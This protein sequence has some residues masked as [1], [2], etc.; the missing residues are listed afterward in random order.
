MI[1]A[2]MPFRRSWRL[3]LL[4]TARIA[5]SIL[6]PG[7]VTLTGAA[8]ME[9]SSRTTMIV[10]ARRVAE[11]AS[12][13]PISMVRL[14]ED[15]LHRRGAHRLEDI[16]RLAP[17]FTMPTVG[18]FGAQQPTIRGVY[19]NIG[20][21]TVGIYLDDVP[22]QI[23]SLEVAGNPDLRAFDLDRVEV[24]RGPQGTLFGANSMGGTIRML[25]RQP[26][27]EGI[28]GHV[29]GELATTRRGGLTR[30]LAAALGGGLVPERLGV[31]ASAYVRHDAG[32]VDRIDWGS[33]AHM[34][35]NIDAVSALGLRLAA[36]AMLGERLEVTPAISYQ[37]SERADLPFYE[38]QR[39][40]FR[41]S[42]S[43]RQPGR[44]RFLLPSLTARLDL[45]GA[46]LTSVTAW[47]DRANRQLV[48]YSGYFGEIVLG[49]AA[50]NIRTP[51]GSA[52]RTSVKQRNFTQE[53]RIASDDPEAT[54]R[55]LIGGFYRRS[56]IVMEQRVT[57]PGIEDLAQEHLGQSIEGIFGL[58]LLPN[59]ESYHSRQTIDEQDI[60]A[61]GQVVWRIARRWETTAG[62][63]ISRSTLAFRLM[64]EGPFAGGSNAIGPKHQHG[65]PVTPYASLSYR[66]GAGSL[67]YLSAG[68]GFRGGGSNG[69]VPAASCAADLAAFGRNSA[70]DS[71]R[72]DSLWSYEAGAKATLPGQN[73]ELMLSAFRIDWRGIQQSIT[74][75]NCGFSYVDNLGAARN[76][77]I[78]LQLRARPAPPL[79]I[80]LSMGHV[81]ARFRRPIGA[82]AADGSGR[83]VAAGD[84]VPYVPRWSTSLAA[85]YA[86][87]LPAR[88]DGF[89]RAEWNYASS[90]RRAPSPRSVA[91]DARVYRGEECQQVQLRAGIGRDAWEISAFVDNLLDN[92]AE[93]F[94]NADLVPVTGTPLRTMMQRPR[95]IGVSARLVL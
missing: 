84:R 2:R 95:T 51:G 1:P 56:R 75:P 70:P 5:A 52:S 19:S 77:G 4:M 59:G 55:W 57:E 68:K 54:A 33:G 12:G 50:P 62:L 39:G 81:D 82:P 26:D 83:I 61:F 64:S 15:D 11:G 17:N 85:Q 10:T 49:G 31:R 44:D 9:G 67:L 34:A 37:K 74:L 46:T 40:P 79:T 66:P 22:V 14:E 38:E 43:L 88:L 8:A 45:G 21:A 63:R 7:A 94:R 65:T 27:L 6:V 35:E 73:I 92:Q 30:E 23:R 69:A 18:T 47:L 25:T 80:D 87:S 76:Q 91:Y 60:A 53:M 71:Y 48:D 20:A 24:L 78:E 16:A 41:Q 58:P 90:Y 36:R 72:S 13:V 3:H 32:L 86:F 29:T 28:G 93:L 42:A 89:A